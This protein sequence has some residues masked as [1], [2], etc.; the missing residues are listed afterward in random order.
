VVTVG[1]EDQPEIEVLNHGAKHHRSEIELAWRSVKN[2]G[3]MFRV[4]PRER[5]EKKICASSIQ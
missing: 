2:I 4:L 3:S 5:F 1:Q